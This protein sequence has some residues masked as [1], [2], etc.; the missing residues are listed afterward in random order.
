VHQPFTDFKKDLDSVRREVFYN[1]PIETGVPIKLVTL[2]K[3]W[4][5]IKYVR[6]RV[7]K[8]LSDMFLIRN[9]MKLGDALFPFFQLCFKV[10]Y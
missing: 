6:V 4:L 7:D 1:I 8:N 9:G 2:I 5:S 10:R 3:M